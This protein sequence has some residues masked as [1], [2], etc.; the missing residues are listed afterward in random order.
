MF[1]TETMKLFTDIIYFQ[2]KHI[3]CVKTW[4]KVSFSC[5]LKNSSHPVTYAKLIDNKINM[6]M[7]V[8]KTSVVL[9]RAANQFYEKK[10]I[11]SFQE[12]VKSSEVIYFYIKTIQFFDEQ[13]KKINE[14]PILVEQVFG[15][16]SDFRLYDTS[17][18]KHN[19]KVY[20]FKRLFSDKDPNV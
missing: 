7:A 17:I 14:K 3:L 20:Y 19:D 5:K 6:N 9:N 12:M 4:Q 2:K 18:I 8:T 15:D 13:G 1:K 11:E 10:E 16:F